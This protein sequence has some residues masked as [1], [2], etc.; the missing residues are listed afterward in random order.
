MLLVSE[1]LYK[2]MN[3]EI[4]GKRGN[5]FK[6]IKQQGTFRPALVKLSYRKN[7]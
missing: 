6:I 3:N 4:I 1:T 5:Y 2:Q 7:N